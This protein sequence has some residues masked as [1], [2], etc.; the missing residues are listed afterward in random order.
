MSAYGTTTQDVPTPKYC[1]LLMG[2]LGRL[3]TNPKTHESKQGG[4]PAKGEDMLNKTNFEIAKLC[5]KS[6]SG[7]RVFA[8]RHTGHAELVQP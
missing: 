6:D 8:A 4:S 2:R 3:T 1:R 7:S 5:A